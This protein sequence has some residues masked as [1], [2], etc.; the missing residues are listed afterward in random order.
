MQSLSLFAA[1]D[2]LLTQLPDLQLD[3]PDAPVVIGNFMARAIADDCI[4]PKFLTSY[5]GKVECKYAKAALMKADT[6]LSMKHGM[7]SCFFWQIGKTST[8]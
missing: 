4:P 8:A 7:V 5:K 6:L 3:T 1:F 2:Y